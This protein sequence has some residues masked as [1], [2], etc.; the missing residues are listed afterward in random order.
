MADN[1][2]PAD[3]DKPA[4]DLVQRGADGDPLPIGTRMLERESYE[5]VIEGIRMAADASSRLTRME[6]EHAE[7]WTRF[8]N[9]LNM[10]QRAAIHIS[11]LDEKNFKETAES[12]GGNV[13]AE[14]E[15]RKARERFRD[16]IKQA[17]G[18]A[19]QMAT[20][21]R[22]DLAWSR[23]A[24]TLEDMQRKLTSITNHTARAARAHGK[25]WV[26]DGYATKH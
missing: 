5:R 12:W 10:F 3:P 22:G 19:R 16:G 4:L 17:A 25:L 9:N 13:S 11:G 6:S 8:R 20:C 14:G 7:Y 24:G 15:W 21:H 26:P 2:I 18:G 1:E 23:M